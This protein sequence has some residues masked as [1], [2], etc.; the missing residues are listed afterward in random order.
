MKATKEKLKKITL[1]L[2]KKKADFQFLSLLAKIMLGYLI[3]EVMIQ[4]MLQF[5]TVIF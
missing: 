4:N 5:L 2:K 1:Y 3:L